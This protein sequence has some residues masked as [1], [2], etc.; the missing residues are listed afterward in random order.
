ME[1]FTFSNEVLMMRVVACLQ[2]ACLTSRIPPRVAP[3]ARAPLSEH[4]SPHSRLALRLCV[5]RAQDMFRRDFFLML[6]VLGNVVVGFGVAFALFSPHFELE[7]TD[8]PILIPS[9]GLDV[10]AGSAFWQSFWG[11]LGECSPPPCSPPPSEHM[12]LMPQ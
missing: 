3:P 1:V 12:L 9:W 5:S 10:S 4:L 11:I 8:G 2:V 6:P 7:N